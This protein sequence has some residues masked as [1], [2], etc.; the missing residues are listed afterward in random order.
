MSLRVKMASRMGSLSPFLFTPLMVSTYLVPGS[1]PVRRNSGFGEVEVLASTRGEAS[2]FFFLSAWWA[3]VEVEEGGSWAEVT[4]RVKVWVSPPF[5]PALHLTK[6]LV[7]L[8][9]RTLQLLTGSGEAVVVVAV[10]GVGNGVRKRWNVLVVEL[11]KVG[12]C[13]RWWESI[14]SDCWKKQC[15]GGMIVKV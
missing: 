7:E 10:E 3:L 15:R 6:A 1:S 2:F 12:K 13:L 8:T 9:L 5:Q 11:G 4:E 14:C